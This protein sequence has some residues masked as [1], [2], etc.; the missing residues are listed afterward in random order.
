MRKDG[1]SAVT[2]RAVARQAGLKPQLVHYY[3]R[4]MEDLFLALVRRY[5]DKRIKR[6][7]QALASQ[8][9]LRA[10]WAFSHDD[11]DTPLAVE[12][13]ALAR[14]YK[15]IRAELSRAGELIREMQ[16]HLYSRVFVEHHLEPYFKS[17]DV[18]AVIIDAVGRA[19]RFEADVGFTRAHAETLDVVH[20]WLERLEGAR[21]EK[22]PREGRSRRRAQS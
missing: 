6:Q 11:P 1:Y 15:S 14:R 4:T 12:C 10:A 13:L 7:A 9:P 3:F 16:G 18:L 8:T 5:T 21:A 20:D 22:L 2:S 17:P 19:L